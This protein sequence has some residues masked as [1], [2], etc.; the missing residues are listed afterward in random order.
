MHLWQPVTAAQVELAAQVAQAGLDVKVVL[1]EVDCDV[2][3][4]CNWRNRWK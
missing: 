4:R 2:W 1:P 3:R